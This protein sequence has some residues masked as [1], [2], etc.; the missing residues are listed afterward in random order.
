M[1]LLTEENEYAV[2]YI[3]TAL[4]KNIAHYTVILVDLGI[5]MNGDSNCLKVC[6]WLIAELDDI[7][8]NL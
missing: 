8:Q 4:P 1:R 5:L 7:N 3:Q 2:V 6:E